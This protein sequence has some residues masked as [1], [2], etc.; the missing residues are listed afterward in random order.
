MNDFPR[1]KLR[2]LVARYGHSLCYDPLRCEGLLRDF[3][4]QN[5]LEVFALSQAVKDGI[6]GELLTSSGNLPVEVLLSRF[7]KCLEDRCGM[8]SDLARWTIE[9]WTLAL[10]LGTEEQLKSLASPAERTGTPKAKRWLLRFALPLSGIFIVLVL[11]L[12]RNGD[13][14]PL[15]PTAP[16][17]KGTI[18]INSEP[19]EAK[20]FFDSKLVGLTPKIIESVDKGNH[21]ILVA[22]D[23]YQESKQEVTI[24]QGGKHQLFVHLTP[25]IPP[26][27]Q[28][29]S[30]LGGLSIRS[31]PSGVE[32]YIDGRYV[33][34]TPLELKDLEQKTFHLAA[35]KDGYVEATESV[36]VNANSV[37]EV[38]L[39]LVP[40]S[41]MAGGSPSTVPL[42]EAAI[43]RLPDLPNETSLLLKAMLDGSQ[44]DQIE[45]V[46]SARIKLQGIRKESRCPDKKLAR[47]NNAAG[48]D[49]ASKEENVASAKR[50]YE[51]YS[52]CPKDVEILNNLGDALRRVGDYDNAEK[53]LLMTLALAPARANGWANLGYVLSIKGD[54]NAG[55]ACFLNA[56]RY[57]RNQNRTIGILKNC[58]EYDPLPNAQESARIALYRLGRLQSTNDGAKNSKYEG[59]WKISATPG[60]E[61]SPQSSPV[62]KVPSGYLPSVGSVD[63]LMEWAFCYV[64]QYAPQDIIKD[65]GKVSCEG[66]ADLF[67]KEV[68]SYMK[69]SAE[70]TA[71]MDN[72]NIDKIIIAIAEVLWTNQQTGIA[73]RMPGSAIPIATLTVCDKVTA[74]GK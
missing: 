53:A 74:K 36:T 63:I 15:S 72:P 22:K 37:R 46:E 13:H 4:G 3:C 6:P 50:F 12:N 52:Y 60:K 1:Q 17:V 2:E 20:C 41:Q 64:K 56:I 39:R 51:A 57:S 25:M 31:E 8:N 70:C 35:N 33:G 47:K 48:L 49:A 58:A 14:R 28:P 44:N 66:Q 29:L 11:A 9:S 65:E 10:G 73:G 62:A 40:K 61:I 68:I 42:S 43:P 69:T 45:E 7:A 34:V 16:L 55:A 59:E 54:V 27:P 67:K 23:G 26:S 19:P 30:L 38:T 71:C 32:C 24:L 21:Y 18:E 5:R